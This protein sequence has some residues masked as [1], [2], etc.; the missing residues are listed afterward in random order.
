MYRVGGEK[1]FFPYSLFY[2]LSLSAPSHCFAWSFYMRICMCVCVCVGLQIKEIM[3][4]HLIIKSYQI[5]TPHTLNAVI[6]DDDDD[7]VKCAHMR[8]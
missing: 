5:F 8:F 2:H 4:V 1:I 6:N 7:D 3:K